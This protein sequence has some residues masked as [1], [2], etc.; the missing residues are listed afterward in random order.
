M[1]SDWRLIETAP[2]DGTPILAVNTRR[3]DLP[4]VVVK[5]DFS[6]FDFHWTDAASAPGEPTALYFNDQFFDFWMPVPTPPLRQAKR[7]G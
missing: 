2:L 5:H 3:P 4:P 6:D 7:Q 1:M